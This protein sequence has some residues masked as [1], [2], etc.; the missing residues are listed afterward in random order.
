MAEFQ[1]KGEEGVIANEA[2]NTSEGFKYFGNRLCP[3]AHRAWWASKEKAISESDPD[4]FEYFHIELG[5]GK[6]AWYQATVN[7]LG[8][9]PALF[10]DGNAIFESNIV[11]EYLDEKYPGRGTQLLPSDPAKRAQVRLLISR[12][13]ELIVKPLY[14]LLMN[15][16]EEQYPALYKAAREALIKFNAEVERFAPAPAGD[17]YLLGGDQFSLADIVAVPFLDRFEATLLYYRHVT[18]L[19]E[20]GKHDRLRSTLALSRQRPAFKVTG[21][22][23]EFYVWAY[24]AYAKRVSEDSVKAHL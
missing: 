12:F 14:G 21:Q 22:L 8:T 11:A 6:P 16:D 7:P 18:L 2:P 5:E 17:N 13:G 19:P 4:G 3:F 15:P 9:V 24:K 10:Q 1:Q 20:D 23:P